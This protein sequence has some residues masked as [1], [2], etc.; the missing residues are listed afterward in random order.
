MDKMKLI[1]VKIP[2]MISPAYEIEKYYGGIDF[3]NI[4]LNC[5]TSKKEQNKMLCKL[6]ELYHNDIPE[7]I[8]NKVGYMLIELHFEPIN[9]FAIAYPQQEIFGLDEKIYDTSLLNPYYDGILDFD[10]IWNKEGICPDPSIYEVEDSILKK[11]LNINNNA[12]KHWLITGHDEEIHVVS[13]SF[14]WRKIEDN[15]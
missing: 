12:I 15:E 6:N 1:P 4:S 5:F 3:V 14:I 2:W 10:D 11:T 13:K 8:W 9:Y 7:E